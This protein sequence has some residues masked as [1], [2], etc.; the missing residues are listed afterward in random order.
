MKKIIVAVIVAILP[1]MAGCGGGGGGG[2]VFIASQPTTAV[3]K[4]SSQGTLPVGTAVAGFGATLELPAGV[5]VKT[6]ASGI[7][8]P[9]VVVPSGL[10]G[11]TGNAFMGSVSYSAATATAKAK[12][13]FAIASAA[14]AGVGVGEYATITLKLSGVNPAVTDFSV[15]SFVPVDLSGNTITVLSPTLALTVN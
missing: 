4:I 12:L 5:T 14:A 3:V 10:L 11:G 13:N 1:V 2:G 7:V 15:T 8:D 9:S 6:D